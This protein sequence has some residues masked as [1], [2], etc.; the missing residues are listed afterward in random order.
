MAVIQLS[1]VMQATGRYPMKYRLTSRACCS[2]PRKIFSP[3][4]R[5]AFHRDGFLL[6][7]NVLAQ[8]DALALA[9]HYG[10]LFAGRFPTVTRL[11]PPPLSCHPSTGGSL[12]R[13]AHILM[14]GTGVR[15]YR[16][17]MPCVRL[18]T[19]GSAALRLRASPCLRPWGRR[20]QS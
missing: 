19:G 8:V 20:P 2:A 1:R 7:H 16:C 4:E 17:R 9:E 10:A 15:V 5:E 14:S 18:S 6:R 13:R 3:A 11:D 12:R